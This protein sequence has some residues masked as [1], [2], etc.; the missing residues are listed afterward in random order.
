[1]RR[2]RIQAG[3][4]LRFT[5]FRDDL[6]NGNDALSVERPLASREEP[7]WA[8]VEYD[9]YTYNE[10]TVRPLVASDRAMSFFDDVNKQLESIGGWGFGRSVGNK[11]RDVYRR[12]P[13]DQVPEEV[14]AAL[15]KIRLLGED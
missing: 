8:L 9:P 3:D 10:L 15:A 5:R 6:V 7:V 14:W 2:S 12:V 4:I 1:M 11:P 13:E